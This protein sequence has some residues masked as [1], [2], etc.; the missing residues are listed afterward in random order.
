MLNLLNGVPGL[1]AVKK[2]TI[3]LHI[4]KHFFHIFGLSLLFLICPISESQNLLN[5]GVQEEPSLKV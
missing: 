1:S 4:K 5:A 3:A 2:P